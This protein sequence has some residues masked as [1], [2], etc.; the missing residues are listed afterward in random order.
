MADKYD[1][2]IYAMDQHRDKFAGFF[3][4]SKRWKY[5][6]YRWSGKRGA[7]YVPGGGMIELELHCRT[8]GVEKEPAVLTVSH[9]GKA[10]DKITFT[11]KGSIIKKYELP[12]TTGKTQSLT[13]EVSRTW[14]PHNTLKNFDR[15]KLGIGVKIVNGK[16]KK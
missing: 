16:K 4:Y 10:L 8:P 6:D 15:R 14:N 7:V 2:N 3:Q 1:L 12:V 5:G 13:L 9:D 11:K